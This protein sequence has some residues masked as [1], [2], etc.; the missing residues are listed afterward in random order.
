MA[1]EVRHENIEELILRKIGGTAVDEG[2][3]ELLEHEL[4][5]WELLKD[6]AC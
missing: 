1:M 4:I 2:A 5:E 6:M 3:A